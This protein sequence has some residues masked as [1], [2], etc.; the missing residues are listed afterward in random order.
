LTDRAW[1]IGAAVANGAEADVESAVAAQVLQVTPHDVQRVA[2][3]Y[4]QNYN[5]AIVLPRKPGNGS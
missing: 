1:Q 2:R 4:L 3:I 5:V